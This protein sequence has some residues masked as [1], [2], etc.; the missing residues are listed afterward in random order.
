MSTSYVSSQSNNSHSQKQNRQKP[1]ASPTKAYKEYYVKIPEPIQKA[2]AFTKTTIAL[3]GAIRDSIKNMPYATPSYDML[4]KTAKIKSSTTLSLHLK[5]LKFTGV[6][7]CEQRGFKRS[8]K[9]KLVPLTEEVRRHLFTSHEYIVQKIQEKTKYKTERQKALREL[10]AREPKR[11]YIRSGYYKKSAV[12]S[13]PQIDEVQLL[14]TKLSSRKLEDNSKSNIRRYADV[15]KKY[16]IEQ[17]QQATSFEKQGLKKM[18]SSL[19][20]NFDPQTLL[21]YMQARTRVTVIQHTTDKSSAS[22]KPYKPFGN[23]Q[24]NFITQEISLEF[25]DLHH[26]ESNNGHTHNIL[27]IVKIAGKDAGYLSEMMCIARSITR[28][29]LREGLV[30]AAPMAYYYRTLENACGI[31]RPPP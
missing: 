20:T 29:K 27:K 18:G 7:D 22:H 13:Y 11:V 30:H 26:L 14:D 28:N 21:S 19:P 2:R 23:E 3:Y 15:K 25:G 10:R 5:V 24:L 8:N 9:Y 6:I 1:E 31:T 12:Q 16:E 4:K 17:L